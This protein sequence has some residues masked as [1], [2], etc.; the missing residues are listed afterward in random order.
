MIGSIVVKVS[1]AR[2]RRKSAE[3]VGR[4]TDLLTAYI[5]GEDCLDRIERAAENSPKDFESCIAMALLGLRG[6]ALRRLRELP[7]VRGIRE[8][9]MIQSRRGDESSRR[10]AVEQLALLGDE[11]VIPALE[12]ALE[13]PVAAVVAAAVRGLMEMPSYGKREELLRS[14]PKRPHLVR[15]LTA[16]GH[17][18]RALQSP[19]RESCSALAALGSTG[20][21]LLMLMSAVGQAGDAPAEAISE[22]L[23]EVARGGRI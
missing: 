3:A 4:I 14:L 5:S 19:E 21:D 18:P 20:R 9:W 6:S 16:R 11:S 1:T 10:Y 8:A 22:S 15:V 17:A 12:I 13:D 23:V 7:E 2:R